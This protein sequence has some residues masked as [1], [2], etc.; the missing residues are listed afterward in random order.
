MRTKTPSGFV[1]NPDK[2]QPQGRLSRWL[3]HLNKEINLYN[4]VAKS[5]QI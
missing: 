3:A 4:T 5:V 1:T 2:L